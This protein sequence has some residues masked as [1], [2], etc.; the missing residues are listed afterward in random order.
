MINTIRTR[1]VIGI[2]HDRADDL[3]GEIR[4][5]IA[6]LASHGLDK[7]PAATHLNRALIE[8]QKAKM[9]AAA[10]LDFDSQVRA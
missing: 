8:L 9:Q 1:E 10:F 6:A 7:T 3:I 5:T 2:A 4:S